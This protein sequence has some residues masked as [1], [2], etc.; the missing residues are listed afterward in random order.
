MRVWGVFLLACLL[1]AGCVASSGVHHVPLRRRELTASEAF[2]LPWHKQWAPREPA[3]VREGNAAYESAEL[4]HLGVSGEYY[5]ELDVGGQVVDV[6]LDTA[7]S[8]LA[9]P[10]DESGTCLSSAPKLDMSAGGISF[11]P[12]DSSQ[13]VG[14]T[15]ARPLVDLGACGTCSPSG[16]CC[17]VQRRSACSFATVEMDGVGMSGA[18]AEAS[19]SMAGLA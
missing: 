7:S 11:I 19:V 17:S 6:R 13:C 8:T 5:I 2:Q 12:C 9:V 1:C 10:A 16:A 14:S 4:M 18:L 15:C 3:R